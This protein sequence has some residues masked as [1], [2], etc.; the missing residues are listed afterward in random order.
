ML[1]LPSQEI[2]NLMVYPGWRRFMTMTYQVRFNELF[3][4]LDSIAFHKLDERLVAL[5]ETK[6]KHSKQAELHITHQDL[7]SEL[8][9]SR[10]VVSRLLKQL[11]AQGKVT[12]GR[13]R[14]KLHT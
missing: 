7:S 5:L 4:V 11:E 1:L 12:L 14:I 2:D 8:G 9:T 6:Q 10:E 13:N 3:Q